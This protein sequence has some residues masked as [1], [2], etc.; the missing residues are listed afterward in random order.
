MK[1]K[2]DTI[3]IKVIN[4]L[5][6]KKNFTNNLNIICKLYE[7]FNELS[8]ECFNSCKNKQL[9]CYDQLCICLDSI[10]DNMCNVM[11]MKNLTCTIY[12]S[13]LCNLV[14]DDSN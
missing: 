1:S 9:L 10:N 4:I 13:G 2:N 8:I 12:E 3:K 14:Y 5:K 11:L 7:I 6:L